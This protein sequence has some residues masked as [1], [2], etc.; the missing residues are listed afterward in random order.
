M[1]TIEARSYPRSSSDLDCQRVINVSRGKRIL[2][3]TVIAFGLVVG[4]LL[5]A[6][7]A[8][9]WW[10][11]RK[12]QRR[13]ATIQAA[14][15]PVSI[16]DI[17]KKF[18]L[19]ERNGAVALRRIGAALTRFDRQL[20]AFS[21]SP[22]GKEYSVASE[23]GNPPTQ[24][25]LKTI[26][27]ILRSS[28]EV[29]KGIEEVMACPDFAMVAPIPELLE[30]CGRLRALARFVELEMKVAIADDKQEI[31]VK[32]GIELL[33]LT[34]RLQSTAVCVN[35]LVAIAMR[36]VAIEEIN[37]ALRHG[38]VS[39]ETHATLDRELTLQDDPNRLVQIL[40]NERAFS[41]DAFESMAVQISPPGLRWW[42][43]GWQSNV[44]DYYTQ[45]IS[46]ANRSWSEIHSIDGG[47]GLDKDPFV[48][49]L[50]P[51]TRAVFAACNR[52]IAMIRS[53]RVLNAFQEYADQ[54]GRAA[55]KSEDLPI[56]QEAMLDPFSGRPLRSKR[57]GDEWVIY[58]V[59]TNEKD[60]G[61]NF[62]DLEDWG[63]APAG[64]PRDE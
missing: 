42:N 27:T 29:E 32:K 3:R 37:L 9:S 16:N 48:E 17:I 45:M 49:L 8:S 38:P 13:L 35:F 58:S 62:K 47:L 51:A 5:I 23:Q 4:A 14:G 2:K 6:N 19:P 1:A 12:L 33:T 56:S 64:Y 26:E 41:V 61:G 28:P 25:Q 36:G 22:M 15:D 54:N 34:R 59:M 10:A 39:A 46:Q 50:V 7:A 31:A 43:R 60:D 44:L 63:L 55:E 40:K 20:S 21:D 11:N 52:D 24:A 57:I 53:L 30:D 18:P